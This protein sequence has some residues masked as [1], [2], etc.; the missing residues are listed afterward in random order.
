MEHD[1]E[2]GS[3]LCR[4]RRTLH[5]VLTH[6]PRVK[7]DESRASIRMRVLALRQRFRATPSTAAATPRRGVRPAAGVP[8]RWS[9]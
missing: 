7:Q 9:R 4:L 3:D 6:L 5:S 8:C 2:I 1:H